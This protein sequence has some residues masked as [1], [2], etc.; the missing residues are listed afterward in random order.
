LQKVPR[1]ATEMTSIRIETRRGVIPARK[2]N[3]GARRGAL[4]RAMRR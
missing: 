1:R 2:R 3:C 4:S